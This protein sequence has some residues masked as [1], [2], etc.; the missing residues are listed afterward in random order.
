MRLW[1]NTLDE[2]TELD[3]QA[4]GSGERPH[5]KGRPTGRWPALQWLWALQGFQER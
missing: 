4:G 2:S 3:R 1:L 5:W